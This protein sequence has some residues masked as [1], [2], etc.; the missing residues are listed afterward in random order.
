MSM[1]RCAANRSIASAQRF[2]FEMNSLSS[3]VSSASDCAIIT[4]KRSGGA[5]AARCSARYCIAEDSVMS[6]SRIT[7]APIRHKLSAMEWMTTPAP[8]GVAPASSYVSSTTVR[9][10]RVEEQLPSAFFIS[11]SADGA[12]GNDGE[13]LT[14]SGIPPSTAG[15]QESWSSDRSPKSR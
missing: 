4:S 13:R 8:P 12:V 11:S 3:R 6:A 14:G 15:N 7:A 5:P 1:C 10:L 2:A 9:P